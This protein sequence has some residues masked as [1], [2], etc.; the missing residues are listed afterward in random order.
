MRRSL[1]LLPI[2]AVVAGLVL[3]SAAATAGPAAGLSPERAPGSATLTRVQATTA[4]QQMAR[5]NVKSAVLRATP[6]SKG[7]KLAS[8]RRGTHVEILDST[9]DWAH[10]RAGKREGYVLKTLLAGG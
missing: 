7:K 2:G 5:V 8:L 6:D 9:G 4:Q 10:V 3:A 1:S